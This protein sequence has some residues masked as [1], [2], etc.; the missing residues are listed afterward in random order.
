MALAFFL[1]EPRHVVGGL[2]YWRDVSAKADTNSYREAPSCGSPACFGGYLPFIPHFAAQGVTLHANS[3][4]PVRNPD[5]SHP[6]A[7]ISSDRL[8]QELFGT[9]IMFWS[10]LD[11]NE[12]KSLPKLEERE[13]REQQHIIQRLQWL[14]RES[15]VI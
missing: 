15:R 8:S 2:T 14:I 11:W 13:G 3:G 10:V 1:A 6:N 4:G 12:T 7:C 9:P 5:L